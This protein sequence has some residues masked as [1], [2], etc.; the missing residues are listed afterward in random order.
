MHQ[1]H[2]PKHLLVAHDFSETAER[3][4]DYAI[5]LAAKL[6]AQVT[7][8]HAYEIPTYGYPEGIALTAEVM[9]DIQ[10]ISEEGLQAV[11]TRSR[12][13]G[14][15]VSSILRQGPAWSEIDAVAKDHGVDLI[16]MGTHGRKGISRAL[17]GSVAEKVVRTAPC[18]VL[19]VR[20]V[21]TAHSK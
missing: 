3:A 6:G 5:E 21:D 9:G 18:P 12:R 13:P 7:V 2:L 19:T 11:V 15:K 20:G 14:L 17:L 1:A 10:R 4:L 8:L 16:V